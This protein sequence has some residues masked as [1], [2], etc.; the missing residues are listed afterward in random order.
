MAPE[1]PEQ[2]LKLLQAS[3]LPGK[4]ILT[5]AARLRLQ[6]ARSDAPPP[7]LKFSKDEMDY[8]TQ[9]KAKVLGIPPTLGFNR[10]QR[11]AA[12]SKA[13]HDK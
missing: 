6:G 3:R 8:F 2:A 10:K 11:R 12:R 13:R 1:T 9:E 4:S 7:K 5:K